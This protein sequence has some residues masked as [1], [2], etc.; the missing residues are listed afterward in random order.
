MA[1]P[2]YHLSISLQ[3]ISGHGASW[4]ITVALLEW[5]HNANYVCMCI[6]YVYVHTH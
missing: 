4:F 5:Y 6:M 1:S 3:R 2:L